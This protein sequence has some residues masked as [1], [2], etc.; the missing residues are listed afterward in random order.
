MQPHARSPPRAEG[1]PDCKAAVPAN[2]RAGTGRLAESGYLLNGRRAG[3]ASSGG[4]A[5][6]NLLL[7][8]IKVAPELAVELL[9]SGAI[10]EA[11][12]LGTGTNRHIREYSGQGVSITAPLSM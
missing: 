3:Q 9:A 8:L 10:Y 5:A 7:P 4:W 2:Q 6:R 1:R 11:V 12:T